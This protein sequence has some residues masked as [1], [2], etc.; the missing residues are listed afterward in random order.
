V[1]AEGVRWLN[2]SESCFQEVRLI[3]PLERGEAKDRAR[4][5]GEG[6]GLGPAR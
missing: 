3:G 5:I 1:V 6:I 4:M 2:L